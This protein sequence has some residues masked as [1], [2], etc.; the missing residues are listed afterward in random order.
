MN[1]KKFIAIILAF[2]GITMMFFTYQVVITHDS[3]HYIYLSNA[4]EGNVSFSEWDVGRGPVFPA[5]IR[6]CNILFGKG[7]NGLLVGMFAFYILMLIGCYLIYKETIKNDENLGRKMKYFLGLLFTFL[8]VL[9]PMII[10]YYHTL[11]TE[12]IAITLA[13][14]GCYLSWKWMNTNFME[15]KLKYVLYTIVLA[16]LTAISWELK[17]PNISTIFF[18][19]LIAAII[20]LIRN[21]NWKNLLQRT[22]TILSCI[23]ILLISTKV[24]NVILEKNGVDMNADRSSSGFISKRGKYD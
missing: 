5:F 22:I 13:V 14:I 23:I 3:S 8:I 6:I 2:I 21:A 9:N 4:F 1:N 16:I 11:L 24:W 12:F 19:I 15:N 10:G 20:S 18:P 7:T 17:Q